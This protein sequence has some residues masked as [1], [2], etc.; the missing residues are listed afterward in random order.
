VLNRDLLLAGDF[1]TTYSELSSLRVVASKESGVHLKLILETSML[2][3]R[4]IVDACAL[5][6]F[7]DW[8]YVKT[9][10]G[11]C[12]HG[13]T[14]EHVELMKQM[15]EVIAQRIAANSGNSSEVVK[16]KVKASGGIRTYSD[17]VSMIQ[18]GADRIGASAGVAIMKEAT[19]RQ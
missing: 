1:V 10:T 6:G 7:A 8:D 16:M 11:F 5:A 3:Q 19:E 4:Q 9:S 13:A 17:S 12:G 14:V 2:E 15:T 18:A